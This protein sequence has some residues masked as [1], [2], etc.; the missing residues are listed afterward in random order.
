MNMTDFL[1]VYEWQA[2]VARRIRENQQ[3][4][5]NVLILCE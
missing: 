2:T 1:N 4:M 5:K 3:M